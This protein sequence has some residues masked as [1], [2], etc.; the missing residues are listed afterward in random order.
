M[1]GS[2][3][4]WIIIKVSRP[5]EGIMLK[6]FKGDPPYKTVKLSCISNKAF[7]GRNYRRYYFTDGL[8][9]E[10]LTA[11]AFYTPFLFTF[12]PHENKNT[13]ER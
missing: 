7:I 5:S 8:P 13:Q 3:C 4:I 12:A 10:A 9:F 6:C 1:G 2:P 11:Y